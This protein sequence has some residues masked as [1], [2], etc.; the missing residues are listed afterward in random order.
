[1]QRDLPLT[2]LQVLDISQGIAGPYCA[3]MLWQQGARVI[4]IEPPEGD[5]GRYVGVVREQHSALSVSYNAGK[6]GLCLDAKAA[7]GQ[8]VLHRLATQSAIFIQNF[9]PGV[10]ERLGVGYETLRAL[11]PDIIYVS[12]SGYG[13]E[14]P[15]AKAPASDSVMQA[16]SGLMFAN[17]DTNGTPRRIGLLLA[18]IATALYAA[19]QVSTALYH[20]ARTGQGTHL[21]LSLFEACAA[22]QI[23]DIAGFDINGYRQGGAVSAPN[24]VFQTANGPLSVLALNDDQFARLCRALERPDWL[25]DPR[26][27][28]NAQRMQAKEI[29][30]AELAEQLLREPREVWTERF[31]QHDVLHAPVRDYVDLRA[32]PQAQHLGLFQTLEQPGVG[33]LNLPGLPGKWGKRAL[34]PAP[35]I[36]EHSCAVLKH[37]G[38]SADEITRL[39]GQGVVQ[40]A[41]H[42]GTAVLAAP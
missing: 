10:A 5:W 9:R 22:L 17:Q 28:T 24:G 39:L 12:I 2:G 25:A 40:Q 26:F 15:S 37:A 33:A 27:E 4:K 34:Q 1:M 16:D 18:D 29:L 23:N 11:R 30:H 20:Q 32:H 13:T 35:A 14:G 31:R 6:E 38:F 21:E 19:Q 42:S 3:Q 41:A 8:K 7:E 36:G